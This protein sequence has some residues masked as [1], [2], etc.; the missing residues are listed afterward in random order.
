M[1]LATPVVLWSG[2]QR[3]RTI[4]EACIEGLARLGYEPIVMHERE[5]REPI[6]DW[7]VAYGL[8]GNLMQAFRDYPASGRQYVNIDLGYWG[9]HEG[10]RYVGFH[11]FAVNARHPTGYF[12]QRLHPGNR[13]EKFG[14]TIKPWRKSDPRD[15]V[16]VAGM[17]GKASAVAGLGY[18]TWERAAIA[19]L[20]KH[21]K[22]PIIYRPKPTDKAAKPLD[23]T[24]FSPKS[25][26]LMG[27]LRA[28][29]AVVTHHS[30]VAVDALIEGV[31][32]FCDDG[33]ATA[34]GLSDLSQIDKPIRPPGRE[35]WAADIAYAQ[36]S[37]PEMKKGTP[38]RHLI[39]EGLIPQ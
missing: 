15:P 9:R 21:T 24:R 3:S 32:V 27:L 37:V 12:Q 16:L 34:M 11:K 18:E 20:R 36:W 25:E 30:N 19:Q 17:S 26:D 28:C 22:R 1:A 4:R 29:H 14:L 39:E 8:P 23:G 7:A 13:F 33:V 38:F 5:Y 31:P 35:Q 2:K 6:G 10:G